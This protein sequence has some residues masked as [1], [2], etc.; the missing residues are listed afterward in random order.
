MS[1]NV[2]THFDDL[3]N[4]LL[5]NVFDYLA[6]QD[7]YRTFV[8][9]NK[10][11]DSVLRSVDHTSVKLWSSESAKDPAVVFFASYLVRLMV[12]ND[13]LEKIDLTC[14]PNVRSLKLKYPSRNQMC[15][16]LQ[17]EQLHCLEFLSL[18]FVQ[19][20]SPSSMITKLHQQIFSNGFPFLHA[21]SLINT[22]NLVTTWS[23]SPGLRSLTLHGHVTLSIYGAILDSCPN[24][25]RLSLY[26]FNDNS[27]ISSAVSSHHSLNFLSI[28]ITEWSTI[29]MIDSLLIHV[30]KLERFRVKVLPPV[31]KIDFSQLACM[32]FDRTPRLYR[33]DCDMMVYKYTID[34]DIVHRLHPCFMRIKCNSEYGRFHIFTSTDIA[35]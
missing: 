1:D 29:T 28:H 10:R 4:E 35:S 24:L 14:F 20:L 25:V 23:V 17:S 15:Q 11:I 12:I 13:R 22:P 18:G 19:N 34:T 26:A 5:R 3:P 2:V 9:L 6:I 21:C 8:G 16:L 30:P 7:L 32:F 31:S 33:F 27:T